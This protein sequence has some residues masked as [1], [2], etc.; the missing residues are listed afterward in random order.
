M[1]PEATRIYNQYIL[2]MTNKIKVYEELAHDIKELTGFN[3]S[4]LRDLF[5]MGCTIRWPEYEL[6][7]AQYAKLAG[8]MY[9][10][11]D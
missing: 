10:R 7:P 4:D 6:T 8:I 11:G 5:A 9:E 2:P 1:N 3:L